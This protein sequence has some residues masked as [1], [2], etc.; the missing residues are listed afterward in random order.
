MSECLNVIYEDHLQ[1]L[2]QKNKNKFSCP[3]S[4]L[5]ELFNITRNKKGRIDED[6][7]RR[8]LEA[9]SLAFLEDQKLFTKL[10]FYKRDA[11]E[12]DGEK[13]IGQLMF[14]WLWD[15]VNE[16]AYK[17]FHLIPE[18]G[19]YKDYLQLLNYTTQ[20]NLIDEVVKVFGEDLI[21]TK[22][23]IDQNNQK[24]FGDEEISLGVKWAPTIKG[25]HDKKFGI[26][27]KIA[28]YMGFPKKLW[29]RPYRKLLTEGRRRIGVVESLMSSNR[30]DN[31][32]M[33]D[34]PTIAYNTYMKKCYPLHIPDKVA[35][36]LDE[37]NEIESTKDQSDGEADDTKYQCL[38]F[39]YNKYCN[40][41]SIV[42]LTPYNTPDS[43]RCSTP[44]CSTPLCS[45]HMDLISVCK[46]PTYS[47]FPNDIDPLN[48]ITEYTEKGI[49]NEFYELKWKSYV[50][51]L[52]KTAS[53]R[54]SIVVPD[55]SNSMGDVSRNISIAMAILSATLTNDSW[56]DLFCTF[57]DSPKLYDLSDSHN[58]LHRIKHVNGYKPKGL[59][60][61]VNSI[62][63]LILRMGNL[64]SIDQ[65]DM[66]ERVYIISDMEFEAAD[67]S[68]YISNYQSINEKF[69]E[70]GYVVPE[71]VFVNLHGNREVMPVYHRESKT[72]I[73]SGIS[74]FIINPLLQ[75]IIV[76]PYKEMISI[77]NSDRYSI[78]Q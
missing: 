6:I 68:G 29:E 67:R 59:Y 41:H 11:R 22:C 55:T 63:S 12:G 51:Q 61:N 31:I 52:K 37:L 42:G 18:F 54:N 57:T 8:I 27:R 38:C 69:A 60:T 2:I 16:V 39:T 34:V 71:I 32:E 58:L 30:W 65:S 15:N 64:T 13:T 40:C 26:A 24:Y 45:T 62:L 44:L 1:N 76:D 53:F 77:L 50:S 28:L 25:S 73:V 17:N 46:T 9:C 49:Y 21:T 74:S 78:I 43:S 10:V 66:I 7:K 70:C 14:A 33:D 5:L 36:Y 3:N 72:Y 48:I 56:K 47:V 35:T 19:Y 23:I 20:Y 75:G 4:K